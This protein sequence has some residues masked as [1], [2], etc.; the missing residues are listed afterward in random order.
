MFKKLKDKLKGDEKP[1]YGTDQHNLQSNNPYYQHSQEPSTEK[2][3]PPPGPPPNQTSSSKPEYTAPPGPP[4]SHQSSGYA[5]TPGPPP[6]YPQ[7]PPPSWDPPPYHDWTVIPDTA[8]LPPPPSMGYDSS[9][10]ANATAEEGDRALAWTKAHPLWPPQALHPST[11]TAIQNAHLALL[12][13]PSLAGDLFPQQTAGHWRIRTYPSCRDSSILS[14]LPL[15][16]ALTDSPLI[17]HHPRTLYFELKVISIGHGASSSFSEADAG[18]AIGFV[19]PPYPTFRL[20]GWER[21]SLGV[22]GDDGRK[23]VNDAWGGND[24]TT[25][26]KPGDTVGIGMTFEVPKNP[27][28]YQG[29]QEGKVLDIKVFF[30]RSGV[31]EGE[32]DG[33]EELDVRSEGGNVGLRGESDLFAAIGVF[34]GVEFDVFFHPGQWLYRPV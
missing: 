27:P 3:Q 2:Y 33:N 29:G 13:P 23:Y 25:A 17:T 18:I 11:Y 24:F 12:K 10:T 30:T 20:P 32:W 31:K 7:Q 34:G 8:L 1:S 21:A 15:Y 28:A 4:P 5:L 6:S 9:P 26:F 22:H 14:N 19:A 16:S